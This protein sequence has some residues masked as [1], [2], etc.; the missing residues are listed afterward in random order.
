[1]R[2]SCLCGAVA[3][4][5]DQ[6]D[7]PIV[8]CHC[9]SCRKAHAA[10]F[11]PTVGVLHTHFRWTQ[12]TEKLT[13]FVSSPGKTRLFC[14]V[15]DS[16]MIAQRDGQSMVLLRLATLDEAPI[17]HPSMHIW[18]SHEVSWLRDADGTPHYEEWYPDH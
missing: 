13:A 2:G 11:A 9:R 14:S 18:M 3:Y 15:C 1:M 4:E 17:P 8:H 5:V 16:Q 10:R 7:R 12:G 6:L